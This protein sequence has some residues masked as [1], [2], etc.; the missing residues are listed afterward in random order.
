MTGPVRRLKR[1]ILV[2]KA[3][4]TMPRKVMACCTH[5]KL[6]LR[7]AHRPCYAVYCCCP[8]SR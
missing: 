3:R 6:H 7:K 4:M 5:C 1:R 2:L 8:C